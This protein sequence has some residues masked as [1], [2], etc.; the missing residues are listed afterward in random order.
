MEH[1][2]RQK[3]TL[4]ELV[5]LSIR[6][7]MKAD[8]ESI[9]KAMGEAF[10]KVW[11]AREVAN[12]EPSGPPMAAYVSMED[13]IAT[14]DVGIPISTEDGAKFANDDVVTPVTLPSCEGIRTLHKGSYTKLGETYQAT[15]A[16]IATTG[17]A[18]G[19]PIRETYLNDPE[20]TPEAEWLT[21]IDFPLG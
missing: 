5:L 2:E 8:P 7:E 6:V 19:W 1:Q 16:Y 4:E 10:G 14:A 11:G 17:A 9:G 13:G 3:V 12:V 21:Q 15:F 20:E 18:P